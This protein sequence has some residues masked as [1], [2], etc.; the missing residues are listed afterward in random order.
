MGECG[1]VKSVEI[2]SECVHSV[3]AMVHPVWIKH[4]YNK[5]DKAVE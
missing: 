1:V 2:M 5:K 4:R 3:C